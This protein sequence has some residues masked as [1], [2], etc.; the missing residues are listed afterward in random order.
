MERTLQR[1]RE[2]RAGGDWDDDFLPSPRE[3][4][5]AAAAAPEAEPAEEPGQ[6]RPP[7]HF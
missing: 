4:K 2:V 3:D 7:S 6:P 5:Q 1:T